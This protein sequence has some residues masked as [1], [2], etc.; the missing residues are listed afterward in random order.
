M[1]SA[2]VYIHL[3]IIELV[4]TRDDEPL[5]LSILRYV[6]FAQDCEVLYLRRNLL[7]LSLLRSGYI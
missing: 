2:V 6:V 5:H 1:A 7:N 3:I 4:K